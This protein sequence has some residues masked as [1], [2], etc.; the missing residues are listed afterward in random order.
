MVGPNNSGK[1]TIISAFRILAVALKRPRAK[2]AERIL[3]PSGGSGYGHAVPVEQI[4]VS[5]EN[6]A[7]NYNDKSSKIEFNLTNGN[8]L[9]LFF[10]KYRDC[11]ITWQTGGAVVSTPVAFKREFPIDIQVVPVLGPLEHNENVVT[12]E[13]VRSSLHTHRAS[14]HFR[15]FWRYY[16]ENWDTFAKLVST[17][18]PGMSIPPRVAKSL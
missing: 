6:V 8:K 1:S 2:R 12:E 15:N 13:T 14:R 5:F 7:T 16:P 4:S 3:L 9:I 17:T 18:W 10:P 11:K